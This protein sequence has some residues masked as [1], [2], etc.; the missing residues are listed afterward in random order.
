[1]TPSSGSGASQV[2][3]FTA[4]SPN[5]YAY[6][7][8]YQMVV[9]WTLDGEGA[10]LVSYNEP[11]NALYLL[12][13]AGTQY[14]GGYAPGTA[15]TI[16]NSQCTL[17]VASSTISGFSNTLTGKVSL[18]FNSSFIGPNE[19]NAWVSDQG[20]NSSGW[21]LL[22][23][24]TAF[25]APYTQLP[26]GLSVS[27]A[28]GTGMSQLFTFHA[29]DLNGYGYMPQMQ[30]QIAS[31]VGNGANVCYVSYDRPGGSLALMNNAGTSLGSSGAL[32]SS[33]VLSNSQCS[34][35]LVQSSATE[36]GND[37]YLNL[38]VTFAS[39]YS[40]A[41]NVYETVLDRTLQGPGWTQVGTWTVGVAMPPSIT[42]TSPLP[43]GNSNY[44]Y[45]QTIAASG[46]TPP[47]VWSIRS[48]ALPSALSL[49]ATGSIS[50][51][52]PAVGNYTFTV[53]VTDSAGLS[54]S[55]TYTLAIS[56][57]PLTIITSSPLPNGTTN[58]PYNG[59]TFAATGGVQFGG[60]QPYHCNAPV[61]SGGNALPSGL[62][63]SLNGV[64]SGTPTTTSAGTYDTMIE[65]IDAAGISQL[66]RFPITISSTVG[67]PN[68]T[69]SS[70]I[71]PV[72]VGQT[73][74]FSATIGSG[75]IAPYTLGW[76]GVEGG[77]N[78]SSVN[79]LAAT[80]GYYSET[81]TI[82]DSQLLRNVGVCAGLV[83]QG[84]T[85]ITSSFPSG[86]VGSS[87]APVTLAATGGVGSYTWSIA[88]GSLPSG[89]TL[90][91]GVI[92]GVP[93]VAGS[94]NFTVKVT[95]SQ[96]NTAVSSTLSLIVLGG[97]TVTTS[98]LPNGT[99]GIPYSQAL[100][101]VGGVSPYHWTLSSGSLPPGITLTSST[102]VLGGTPTSSG[103]YLFV[104][105]ATDSVS[106]TANTTLSIVIASAPPTLSVT[107]AP[108]TVPA[109]TGQPVNFTATGT[110][111]Y[112]SYTFTWGGVVAGMSG[113]TA[114]FVP[115]AT[116]TYTA[117][118]TVTDSQNGTS[119]NSCIV[120]VQAGSTMKEYI[121]IGN[122]IIAIENN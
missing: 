63:L 71:N 8:N 11:G 58:V 85:V 29:N 34:I 35:S 14:L 122:R 31:A 110:G 51:N 12:N 32:G 16:S 114:S 89:L 90:N 60:G 2:F 56:S 36:S 68:V 97:L 17:N 113:S 65:V 23:S 99:A 38:A 45:G 78:V 107:C 106:N 9:N 83:V 79:F 18:T 109:I 102:G 30:M 52:S 4:S 61:S 72:Q 53:L 49:S 57:Q 47:Y 74:T 86:A 120:N 81:V 82:T 87:Y 1:V 7:E 24:W 20:G 19:V 103:S 25:P 64:L 77:G 5:G 119:S 115:A 91:A 43:S 100:S 42:T 28:N 70:S 39:G 111:G 96:S 44:R 76:S 116:G 37:L 54:A 98:S 50:G 3:T 6:L 40:G 75:G 95:D 105:T 80:P 117:N 15:N 93:T 118:V 26:S 13:D 10:C 84:L 108:T 73:V 33:T 21:E 66:V 48:G 59:L 27:P 46:G 92:S 112:P 104:I 88:S 94:S 55:Q 22:G 62:S 67:G 41:K 69:C 121:R 101:A